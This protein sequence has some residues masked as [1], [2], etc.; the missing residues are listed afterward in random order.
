MRLSY[1]LGMAATYVCPKHS[2]PGPWRVRHV[3]ESGMGAV[4]DVER[5]YCYV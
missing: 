3:V 4:Q 5:K 1:T 2:P